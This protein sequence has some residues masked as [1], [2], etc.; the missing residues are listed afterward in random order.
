MRGLLWVL[1][2]FALAV[3]ISLA[4]NVNDGYVLL[5]VPPY[6]G[7]ISLNLAIV[8]LFLVFFLLYALVR[9]ATL[10]LS[11]P[12]KV[13]EFRERRARE[14]ALALLGESV[15]QLF[16]G[17]YERALKSAAKA[18]VATPA[19][20]M[21]AALVAAR[22][23]FALGDTARMR[24]WLDRA[25][26]GENGQDARAASLMLE[27]EMLLEASRFA[28]AAEVLARLR[29]SFRENAAALRLELRAQ[30]GCGKR[31]EVDRIVRQLKKHG[32]AAELPA[33][34]VS[35]DSTDESA[36]R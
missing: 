34:A 36:T 25:V 7:E 13:G 33:A 9:A 15:R 22:A 2:L 6:R 28:E 19:A 1:G 5:V 18:H 12:R 10:T 17:S 11:L 27:A 26:Q 8:I 35:V 21:S 20:E 4:A 16:E 14:K 31:D 30:Q 29:E 32:V 23:A 3:G 24:E